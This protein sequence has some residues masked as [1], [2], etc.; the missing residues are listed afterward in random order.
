MPVVRKEAVVN[1]TPAEMFEL[2]DRVEKYPEFVPACQRAEVQSRSVDTVQATL[3]FAHGAISKSFTTQ[4]RLQQDKMIEIKLVNGPFRH[5][6]GFWLFTP[7]AENRC[8]IVLDLEF[9]FASKLLALMF[10]PVFH[11]VTNRLVD[12]FCK[13]AIDVYGAR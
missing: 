9:E 3:H 12:V 5:L 1:Y 11:Q 7:L 2:V 13:R 10:G 6:E 4:N 8:K